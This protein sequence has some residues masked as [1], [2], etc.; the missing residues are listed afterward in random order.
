MRRLYPNRPGIDPSTAVDVYEAYRP[1]DPLAP[2]VRINMV[3]ALDGRVVGD[4]GVSGTLGGDGDG[5]A[6]FAMRH[7]ADGVVAGAG[8]VRA[9]GYGPM[10]VRD[11]WG[12][13]RRADGRH[14]PASIVIVT[15]SLDLDLESRV[16]TEAVAPTIV[17]TTTDAP[18]ERVAAV[19]DAG[20]LVVAAG[21][22]DVN[23]TAGFEQLRSDHGLAHLLVEG[24]PNLN[25]Q[26]LTAGLADEVCVTLAPALAGGDDGKRIVDGLTERRDVTLAQVLEA[27]GELLLTYRCG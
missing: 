1:E 10:R 13:R 15:R 8:T 22:G 2:L 20:G 18:T 27:D 11:G 9:E 5:Q 26:I 17:L 12:E 3:S 23:L 19:E 21:E 6:F 25:G 14:G 16:F 4:D 7:N 24:G